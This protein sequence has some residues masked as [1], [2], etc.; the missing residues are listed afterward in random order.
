MRSTAVPSHS[1]LCRSLI[2]RW[3]EKR[4]EF[5]L[6]LFDLCRGGALAHLDIDKVGIYRQAG[7][8][9]WHN[10]VVWH[11]FRYRW[12]RRALRGLYNSVRV[13]RRQSFIKCF[14]VSAIWTIFSLL[15]QLVPP[16]SIPYNA[17]VQPGK[18]L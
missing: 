15:G 2:V 1:S 13:T 5:L 9:L 16:I 17:F 14:F 10:Y 11:P 4:V 12:P 3:C 6:G 7:Y 18:L 8:I